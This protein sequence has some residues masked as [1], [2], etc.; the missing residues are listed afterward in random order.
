M[1]NDRLQNNFWSAVRA[2]PPSD[3]VPYA[4]ERRIMAAL[5]GTEPLDL[6]AFWG[7]SLWRA[8]GP[9]IAIMLAVSLWT[10]VDGSVNASS[11]LAADLD[12][13]VWGPLTSLNESW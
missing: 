7:R 1:N 10:V 13:T 6:W 9:C 5:K 11:N 12:R 4:F 8:A 3:S 2:L